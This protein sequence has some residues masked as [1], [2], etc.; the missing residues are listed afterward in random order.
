[1]SFLDSVTVTYSTIACTIKP[2]YEHVKGLR[3]VK[4]THICSNSELYWRDD[5]SKNVDFILKYIFLNSSVYFLQN[6][7]LKKCKY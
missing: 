4:K 6:S 2:N 5:Q 1:M 7:T 3:T